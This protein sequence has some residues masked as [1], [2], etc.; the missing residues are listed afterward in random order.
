MLRHFFN[1]FMFK[2]LSLGI[3][4]F[5]IFSFANEPSAKIIFLGDI[6]LD[7]LPGKYVAR[8]RDPFEHVAPI[9]SHADL[10]VGNL[11]FVAS[12]KGSRFEKP[13]NFKAPK[14]VLKYVARHLD[15]VSMANNHTGDY[16]HEG[17]LDTLLAL[18]DFDIRVFGAGKDAASAHSPLI[19]EK[20]GIKIAILGYNEFRPRAFQALEK[21]PGVAWSEDEL[22]LKDIQAVRSQVD[23]V[24]PFM[25][26]GEEYVAHPND[27]QKTLARKLINAG[28]DAVVGGHPHITEG[29]E[30]YRGKPIIYSLGNFIFDD[31]ADSYRE[32]R[33]EL[34][35]ISR[36]SWVLSLSVNKKGVVDWSTTVTRTGDDGFPRIVPGALSPSKKIPYPIDQ[37]ISLQRTE[38]KKIPEKK[39][40][41]T[42]SNKFSRCIDHHFSTVNVEVLRFQT[43]QIENKG[44]ILSDS[45]IYQLDNAFFE[46]VER[47][48]QSQVTRNIHSKDCTLTELDFNFR[49]EY[50]DPSPFSF[51][52]KGLQVVRGKES[53]DF[54]IENA[55]REVTRDSESDNKLLKWLSEGKALQVKGKRENPNSDFELKV[56]VIGR[57]DIQVDQKL[58]PGRAF[59]F[60]VAG[61]SSDWNVRAH[62]AGYS[63]MRNRGYYID[64]QWEKPKSTRFLIPRELT[65]EFPSALVPQKEIYLGV[66]V[67]KQVPHETENRDE[68]IVLERNH[69]LSFTVPIEKQAIQK[70]GAKLSTP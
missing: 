14:G 56:P 47:N 41:C 30:V 52:L 40:A 16:G 11:E 22:V 20:N 27:R 21:T 4:L 49:Y 13:Y 69:R 1:F 62:W 23:I 60:Q 32:N 68:L 51:K 15:A 29:M 2:H 26:W 57:F 25:H 39:I 58:T 70:I 31:F 36:T 67:F 63:T 7:R 34:R 38:P 5:S 3:F 48:V 33:M 54:A 46:S 10:R 6:M 37:L 45:S 12:D 64:C 9:L 42:E 66:E 61:L 59:G 8:G 43:T 35:E 19:V 53:I 50:P 44:L 65:K 55:F 24:I 17:L 28:A 18:K